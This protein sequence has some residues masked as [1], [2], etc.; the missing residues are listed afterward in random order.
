MMLGANTFDGLAPW[1]LRVYPMETRAA[2][3]AFMAQQFPGYTQDMI[4]G[5]VELYDPET[6][7]VLCVFFFFSFHFDS[8]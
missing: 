5:M 8:F 6:V 3:D 4:D 1:L 2:Y 7:S